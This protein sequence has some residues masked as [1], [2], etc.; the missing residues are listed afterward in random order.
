MYLYE[1]YGMLSNESVGDALI[2]YSNGADL[3]FIEIQGN[4]RPDQ[5][6]QRES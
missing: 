6:K 2:G 1:E 5:R 3:I 4:Y